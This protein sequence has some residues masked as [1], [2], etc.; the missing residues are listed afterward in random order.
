MIR[1]K[2]RWIAMYLTGEDLPGSMSISKIAKYIILP[3]AKYSISIMAIS[4]YQCDYILVI[5]KFDASSIYFF[6]SPLIVPSCRVFKAWHGLQAFERRGGTKYSVRISWS[7]LVLK[8]SL[9]GHIVN[10][11]HKV[12][13]LRRSY[14]RI[15]QF[16]PAIG[17]VIYESLTWNFVD[18]NFSHMSAKLLFGGKPDQRINQFKKTVNGLCIISCIGLVDPLIR[19]DPK[20]MFA[21]RSAWVRFNFVYFSTLDPCDLAKLFA[22]K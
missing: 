13:T 16:E 4:M 9:A 6:L 12:T 5:I 2:Q 18:W 14:V 22:A 10:E 20:C 8:L 11:P 3:L 19:F 21:H 15:S 17:H 1:S 7:S